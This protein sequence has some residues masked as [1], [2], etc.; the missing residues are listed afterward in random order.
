MWHRHKQQQQ[1]GV[2]FRPQPGSAPEEAVRDRSAQDHE[3]AVVA[4][5][6][7][8]E[9]A[10]GTYPASRMQDGEADNTP[11]APDPHVDWDQVVQPE[12][13]GAD[14][15]DGDDLPLPEGK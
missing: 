5:S 1:R 12:Q 4:V 14:R 8:S 15:K 2:Q 13:Q 6:P 10:P 7:P 9:P 3:H 11:S